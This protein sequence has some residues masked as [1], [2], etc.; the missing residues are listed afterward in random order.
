LNGVEIVLG[1]MILLPVILVVVAAGAAFVTVRR[2]SLRI[3]ADGIEVRNYPDP[4]R[5]FPLDQV[6]RFDEPTRVGFLSSLR[7]STSVL[8]LMDGSRVP[9][10]K[11]SE[12][13]AGIGVDA[14]NQRLA[15][16]RHRP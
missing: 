13:Q 16:L 10:R 4:P 9:V 1:A 3:T 11:A 14:L 12:P 2:S 6:A 15:R 8:V 7:P 5:V